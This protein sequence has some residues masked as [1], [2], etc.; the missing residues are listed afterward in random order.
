MAIL[1]NVK[2]RPVFGQKTHEKV[3]IEKNVI[4]KVCAPGHNAIMPKSEIFNIVIEKSAFF[5]KNDEKT[6]CL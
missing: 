3:K 5:T 6:E 1:E 4:N 2:N